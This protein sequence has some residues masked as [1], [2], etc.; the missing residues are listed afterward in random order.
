MNWPLWSQNN[1]ASS[2]PHKTLHIGSM[3]QLDIP[4]R[5]DCNTQESLLNAPVSTS[6]K[7]KKDNH[8]RFKRSISLAPQVAGP[9]G[10]GFAGHRA[11][12]PHANRRSAGNEVIP[13]ACSY[14]H[15]YC[16]SHAGASRHPPHSRTRPLPTTPLC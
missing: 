6:K 8:D 7:H 16:S 12:R 4:C 13:E 2:T 5:Q 10:G 15:P 1:L 9:G 3:D 11:T 14:C